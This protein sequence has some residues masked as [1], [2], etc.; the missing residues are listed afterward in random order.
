MNQRDCIAGF[1]Q[2]PDLPLLYVWRS[3]IPM[4]Y[5][6]TAGILSLFGA[7]NILIITVQPHRM[8]SGVVHH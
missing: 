1:H 8:R 3:K 6:K 4:A 2:L 5:F 7:A